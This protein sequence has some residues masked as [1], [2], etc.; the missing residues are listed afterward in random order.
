MNKVFY[1]GNN[2]LADPGLDI[3]LKTLPYNDATQICDTVNGGMYYKDGQ[4][5]LF[6]HDGIYFTVVT[7]ITVGY[8]D[9]NPTTVQSKIWVIGLILITFTLIPTKL[10]EILTLMNSQS[11][12]RRLYY[13]YSEVEHVVVTGNVSKEAIKDFCIELFHDDHSEGSQG[14]NA[15]I[16]QNKDPK[17]EVEILMDGY[18]KNMFYIAGDPLKH[19]DM[20][21]RCDLHK[22]SACII[23]TNKN[24]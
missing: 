16:I 14:T 15:V 6:M 3:T 22:A 21:K 7:F 4:S 10:A 13:K 12:Y 24:S 9:I 23:L 2:V 20:I 17:P 1:K 5:Q 19:E 11:R 8:G 18:Q